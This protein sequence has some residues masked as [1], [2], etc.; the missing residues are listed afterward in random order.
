MARP[1]PCLLI[2]PGPNQ[3]E[4]IPSCSS[5]TL[6]PPRLNSAVPQCKTKSKWLCKVLG[7]FRWQVA[8]NWYII[9]FPKFEV[10]QRALCHSLYFIPVQMSIN[11]RRRNGRFLAVMFEWRSNG[12]SVIIILFLVFLDSLK[13]RR[14]IQDQL[15]MFDKRVNVII[16]LWAIIFSFSNEKPN[17]YNLVI[18]ALVYC[19]PSAQLKLNSPF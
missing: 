1:V 19:R 8:F 2:S 12:R 18:P 6:S 15:F 17:Y 14:P 9:L 13:K 16:I 4:Q 7:S 3:T 10:A 11:K 5:D